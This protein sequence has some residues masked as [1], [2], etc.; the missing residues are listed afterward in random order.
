MQEHFC[1]KEGL[2]FNRRVGNISKKAELKKKAVEEKKKTGDDS[3]RK[4]E[5]LKNTHTKPFR[6]NKF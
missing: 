1:C 6:I 3:Q 5:Q 4:Y 2:I